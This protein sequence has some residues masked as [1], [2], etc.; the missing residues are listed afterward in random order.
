MTEVDRAPNG[1][2]RLRSA[3]P[4]GVTVERTTGD[5]FAAALAAAVDRPAVGTRLPFE[6]VS[7]DDAG[8][9]ALPSDGDDGAS[10]ADERGRLLQ[11]AATGVT[12][13]GLAIAERGT[14]TVRSRAA[15]DELVSLYPERHVAVLRAS[16]VVPDVRAA[17]ESMGERVAASRT[18]GDVTETASEV[19]TTG[20]S[21][22]ADMGAM[23]EGV[24]GPR[25]VCVLA[26]EDG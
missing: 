21:A 15:G 6:G 13:A 8:I 19:L 25:E 1:L 17:F 12:P 5:D 16:D 23:V 3:T 11:E 9:E 14:V 20:P 22:T 10:R 18:G 26:L 4:E 7:I 24:H 2:D